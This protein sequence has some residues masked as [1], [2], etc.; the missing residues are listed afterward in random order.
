MRPALGAARSG[1]P[2]TKKQPNATNQGADELEKVAASHHSYAPPNPWATPRR[3]ESH[4][5]VA[6]SERSRMVNV[7][8]NG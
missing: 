3:H 5:G 1:R 2:T 6:Y 4:Q 8:Q 7:V